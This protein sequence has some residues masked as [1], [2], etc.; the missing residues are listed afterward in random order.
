M[1]QNPP[2]QHV[3]HGGIAAMLTGKDEPQEL[4][5]ERK[6]CAHNVD[7]NNPLPEG[8]SLYWVENRASGDTQ[9]GIESLSNADIQCLMWNVHIKSQALLP[10]MIHITIKNLF[11][12]MLRGHSVEWEVTDNVP[13][14]IGAAALKELAFNTVQELWAEHCGGG[15][16]RLTKA[17]VILRSSQDTKIEPPGPSTPDF[18]AIAQ[19]FFKHKGPGGT[20][21][22]TFK[23]GKAVVRLQVKEPFYAE[24]MEW[25]DMRDEEEAKRDLELRR[26]SPSPPST[27]LRVSPRPVSVASRSPSPELLASPSPVLVAKGPPQPRLRQKSSFDV[28]GFME[29]NAGQSHADNFNLNLSAE[30]LLTPPEPTPAV[31]LPSSSLEPQPEAS[32]KRC[33]PGFRFHPL[34]TAPRLGPPNSWSALNGLRVQA[35]HGIAPSAPQ[36]HN[37]IERGVVRGREQTTPTRSRADVH[38]KRNLG[39]GAGDLALALAVP[40]GFTLLVNS[41]VVHVLVRGISEFRTL[42]EVIKAGNTSDLTVS[43]YLGE[44]RAS[45]ITLRQDEYHRGHYKQAFFGV[46]SDLLFA[47][48]ATKKVCVKQVVY[49]RN[50]Y[51][52]PFDGRKQAR[53]LMSDVQCLVWAGPLHNLAYDFIAAQI[54]K[55]GHPDFTIPSMRF[56]KASLASEKVQRLPN[57]YLIEEMIE[58]ATENGFRKYINNDSAVPLLLDDDSRSVVLRCEFLS[59]CQHVQ[60][61]KTNKTAFVTD[62]Q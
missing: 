57:V 35:A 61:W 60:Y 19:Q 24:F 31:I 40:G 9:D 18:D 55:L 36:L 52:V 49:E 25:R 30:P 13:V 2:R 45:T 8:E 47:G 20:G 37:P 7:Y 56:V 23:T 53:E 38:V 21:P 16:F 5:C 3:V 15:G 27:K 39:F 32:V 59:F 26:T 48:V 34:P 33:T 22:L 43:A 28:D 17:D 54:S 46:S 1:S 42:E 6:A 62:Y 41:K 4:F 10:K 51:I 14:H 50:G 44:E 58:P 11:D 29:L 12:K